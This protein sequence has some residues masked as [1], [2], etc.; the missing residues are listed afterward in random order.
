MNYFAYRSTGF[1]IRALT[2]LSRAN[3]RLHGQENIPPSTSIFVANHFTRLETVFLTEH[4]FHLTGKTAVWSLASAEL[5]DSSLGN[6]LDAMGA[7]ST[8]DPQRDDLIVR[9]L[10]TGEASWIIYP[11][12]RMVKDKKI[13]DKGRFV[14]GF[15]G[16]GYSP[17]TGAASLALRTEFYR[18][19]LLL[20]AQSVPE[21]AARLME[22]FQIEE[23][24]SV[25]DHPIH[26]VPVNIT[27]FPIRAHENMIKTI[28]DWIVDDMPDRL[29][30]EI[31]T[32]STMLL[33]G[34]DIDIR[35]GV[36]VDVG[37]YTSAHEISRDIGCTDCYDFDD[38]IPSLPVLRSKA[39]ELMQRYMD[40]IYRMTTVNPEHVFASILRWMPS[41]HI[42]TSD[43]KRRAYLAVA[44]HL[45]DL[46][47]HRHPLLDENPIHL[48]TDD[49]RDQFGEFVMLGQEQG[50]LK[51]VGD[52]LEKDKTKLLPSQA[53][54][55]GEWHRSRLDNTVAVIANEVEPLVDL[56][57]RLKRLARLPEWYVKR[58]VNRFLIERG[59]AEYERDYARFYIESESRAKAVGR[60]FL[61]KGR[62]RAMGV[63]LL[64]GYMAAP[65]EVK[66][67]A[68]YLNLL[69]H[70]VYVPRVK[71]HG[72]A[73]EDLAATTYEDWVNSV[74]EG[75]AIINSLCRTVV[76]G[77][78]SNGAGLALDA[79]WRLPD[80]AAVFA[81]CPP[82][83]LQNYA[84]RFV[85]ALDMWNL[86]MSKF[87]RDQVKKE[88]VENHPEHP[89]INYVRNP[90][91]SVR[92][93][94]L[95]MNRL[96]G[97]LGEISVP[98]LVV[99]S[100]DDPVVDEKGSRRVF[101]LLGSAEKR[102]ILF[103]LDRH[104]ILLG[105]GAR[106]VHRTVGSFIDDLTKGLFITD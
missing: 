103:N 1:A 89:D 98:A 52:A 47:I 24:E 35:F 91:A 29:A 100:I 83:K 62:S 22:L 25:R 56:Q 7:I 77:G 36:P 46:K 97:K 93:L 58:K 102:Y 86:V 12:G 39:L 54:D 37:E 3:I 16:G 45:Q 28:A 59:L 64:H 11:E 101:E 40:A 32:E 66:E 76:V 50:V 67:L 55:L 49:R 65:Y 41:R 51:N 14:V 81:I 9:S 4:I 106:W 5:F 72:T 15:P 87:G 70:W 34:V 17:H 42:D 82:L 27:Y 78:F 80:I 60:P 10:L 44:G 94:E 63:V 61:L 69:G 95:F 31:M 68:D 13:Y 73:P 57:R 38:P 74:D 53:D 19:R 71:G 99:Q 104:G 21:E 8:K 33:T 92:Q 2:G 26:I 18:R 79:A 48:L 88:F 75:Y 6:F 84:A 30:E 96:E 105:P 20:L 23:I 90:I 43:F 85:P